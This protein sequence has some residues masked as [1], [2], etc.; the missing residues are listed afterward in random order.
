M[1]KITNKIRAKV[2]ERIR[3]SL[4]EGEEVLDWTVGQTSPPEIFGIIPILSSYHRMKTRFWLLVL[5]DQRLLMLKF[6]GILGT[7]IGEE[8]SIPLSRIRSMRM[9]KGVFFV[10][11]VISTRDGE[12]KFKE[13]EKE[14]AIEFMRL[15]E[16]MKRP[17]AAGAKSR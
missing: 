10:A 11:L 5:T 6:K 4:I 1:E 14:D 9:K 13:M 7:K 3:A 2:D 12:L 8:Q 15:F 17:A 16:Q